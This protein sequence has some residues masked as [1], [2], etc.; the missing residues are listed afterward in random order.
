MCT[1]CVENITLHSNYPA[2]FRGKIDSTHGNNISITSIA[3]YLLAAMK[4]LLITFCRSLRL[5]KS[6]NVH[7]TLSEQN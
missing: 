7:I 1:P 3:E 6:Q 2:I 4:I 5:R